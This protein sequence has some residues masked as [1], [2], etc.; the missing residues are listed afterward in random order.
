LRRALRKGIII[1]TDIIEPEE[2]AMKT[3]SD[4][5]SYEKT[6]PDDYRPALVI[7]LMHNK[8]QFIIVNVFSGLLA[9][10]CVIAFA[11]IVP[12]S[13]IWAGGAQHSAVLLLITA[14]LMFAYIVLHEA[15]HGIT[16]KAFGCDRV[17]FG[18]KGAYAFAGSDGWYLR[19]PYIVIALAP[20]VVWGIVFAAAMALL[21]REWFWVPALLQ[22]INISGAA[23]DLYVT[24]VMHR[25]P[26]HMLIRDTGT[27]MT[28]YLPADEAV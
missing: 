10:I 24:W 8:K 15:V 7:D 6:L 18:F 20:I 16:M 12:F 14:V 1:L 9:L 28:G 23:G 17:R 26:D 21:P 13:A 2:P 27:A 19:R 22:T 3:P 5:K 25:Y 11:L 4:L